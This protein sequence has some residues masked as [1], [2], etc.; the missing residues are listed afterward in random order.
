MCVGEDPAMGVI[1][2]FE[3]VGPPPT[4][5]KDPE[6]LGV[7]LAVLIW[8]IFLGVWGNNCEV[9]GTYFIGNFTGGV[10]PRALGLA[11]DTEGIPADI[12]G[13]TEGVNTC[14]FRVLSFSGFKFG[15]K[16]LECP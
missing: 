7:I 9:G 3:G 8:V 2:P 13:F 15:S 11:A 10:I 6:D 14:F 12:P 5:V 1:N 16:G 4:G